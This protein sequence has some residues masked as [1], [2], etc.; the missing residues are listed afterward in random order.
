MTAT[1]EK[2][3]FAQVYC[4]ICTHTVQAEVEVNGRRVRVTPG[5]RCPRCSAT[6]DAGAVLY[7]PRAA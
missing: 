1:M 3:A 2:V 6:L 7:V 5:Q 4:P